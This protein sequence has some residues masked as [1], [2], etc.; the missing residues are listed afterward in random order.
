MANENQEPQPAVAAFT[1]ALEK[2]GITL[3]AAVDEIKTSEGLT[4]TVIEVP[5]TGLFG[6][7]RNDGC[8]INR[9]CTVN[10]SCSG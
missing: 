9:G 4:G 5:E 1:Q 7:K 8:N 2:A 10:E 6:K 3:S